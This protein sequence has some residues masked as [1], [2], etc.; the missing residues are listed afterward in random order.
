MYVY[1]CGE[2]KYEYSIAF[3]MPIVSVNNVDELLLDWEKQKIPHLMIT[4]GILLSASVIYA[5][6]I[7]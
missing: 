2:K 7:H 4:I 6:L 1:G 3:L 5:K